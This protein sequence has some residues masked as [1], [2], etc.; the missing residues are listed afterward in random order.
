[1][2]FPFLL[3]YEDQIMVITSTSMLPALKLND[4]IVIESTTI[5]KIKKN[6][7]IM[8]ESHTDIGIVTH[9]T[10]NI[11]EKYGELVIDTKGDNVPEKDR[12]I[13]K[14]E[15]FIGKAIDVI[16]YFGILFVGPVKFTL[17]AIVI[18]IALFEL[19]NFMY[20]NK[21]PDADSTSQT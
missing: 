11:Y 1:M 3:F 14:N 20:Y 9:R 13:V 4:L 2:I 16:P 7:I 18:I 19:R 5:D 12:W 8:F 15:D 17:V 21:K 6:D 10:L